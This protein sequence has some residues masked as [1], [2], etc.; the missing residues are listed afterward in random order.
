MKKI[1]FFLMMVVAAT[2]T[3]CTSVDSKERGICKEWGGEVDVNKVY[4]PGM[5]TGVNWLW[6]DMVTFDV[7]QQTLVEKYEFNDKN[8]M[9]TG[10]EVSLDYSI[11]P[12]KVGYYYTKVTN[13]EVKL[14]KTLKSAA[15]EVIPQYTASELNLTKRQEAEQKLASILEKELP[16]FYMLFDRVQITDVD[17]PK[18]IAEAA[19]ATAK[20]AE[21]NKLA[22]SKV[23]QAKNNLDAAKYDAEAKAILS[24]PEMLALKKL[25]VEMEWAKR[26]TSPY[27]NNNVFGSETA[28]VRGLK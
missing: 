12:K 19:E 10:V 26:A 3:S 8:N 27:G 21:L 22:E 15:K 7:S 20:Q 9:G 28:I 5:H 18:A 2:I 11:D 4:E 13:P 1:I 14:T 24:K 23:T 25:E 17:I 16:G 6:D